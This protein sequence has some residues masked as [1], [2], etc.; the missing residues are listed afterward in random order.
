MQLSAMGIPEYIAVLASDA[1]APGGGSA[2]ALTGAQ[3]AALCAMVCSLTI[4]KKKYEEHEALCRQVMEKSLA[5]KSMFLD[6][7]NRDTEAFNQVSAVFVMPK[8]TEEQKEARKTAMQNGLK[9]CTLTPMEMMEYAAECLRLADSIKGKSNMSA[10]SD[11]GC[12]ALNLAAAMRGAWYNVQ[13]NLSGIKDEAFVNEYRTRGEKLIADALP[14]ADN[15]AQ[16]VQDH[17]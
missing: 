12:S 6:V 4:G 13:I 16:F 10:V 9:A 11:L 1:G 2:S 8:D 5:L 7:M 14:L 17:M 3:G 15:I